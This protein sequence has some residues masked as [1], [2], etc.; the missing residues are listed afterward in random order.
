MTVDILHEVACSEYL[1][2][3]NPTPKFNANF[4]FLLGYFLEV[5]F[6]AGHMLLFYG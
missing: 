5:S 6:F 1:L 4:H 2:V 3:D